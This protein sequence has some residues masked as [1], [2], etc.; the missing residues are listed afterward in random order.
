MKHLRCRS[1]VLA[2]AL[3]VGLPAAAAGQLLPA[4]KPLAEVIDHYLDL[5]LKQE[6]VIPAG[7]ADDATLIRRLTLDLV[8]RIPTPVETKAFVESTDPDKRVRLV[9]RLMAAPAF[10]RHQATELDTMLMYG[11]RMSIR[12]YL[13]QAL[14]E[15]RSWDRI[16]RD[17]VVPEEGDPK[18]K[19]AGEFLK[20]R[21]S[22][23]DRLTNDVSVNFFG[24]NISC[25]QCHDHP[26][27]PDWKQD[28]FFGMKA[29]FGRTFD[30]GGFLAEREFAVIK[31]RTTEGQDRQ[32]RL[33]FLTG[34]EVVETSVKEPSA[35]EQKKERERFETAKKNKTAPPRPTFSARTQLV[36]MALEPGQREFFARSIVN[37]LWHRFYGQGLVMPLDQM[38]S[39]NPPSHPELLEWLAR[40]TAEHNY[41]LRRLI[42][43][44]VLSNAYARDS[45]W[46]KEDAP[47][48]KLFAVAAVR[49]L[50]PMQLA[51]SLSVA[52]SAPTAWPAPES[53]D[54]EKRLANT[55][56]AA[57]GFAGSIEQPRENFQIGVGEALLFSNSDR[58]QKQYL[59]DA[60]NTLIGALK[61][62][63]EEKDVVDVAVRTVFGRPPSEEEGKA[64][65]AFLAK[66]GDRPLQARRDIVWILLTSTEFRFNH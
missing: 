53:D 12:D 46:D 64:L 25:A 56:G 22:D 19:S 30:N 16:F 9:D 31:F 43:G 45:R 32:A 6:N 27:V 5:K 36:Q 55:E 35:E 2:A 47:D 29:F 14:S 57:R 17:V 4:E 59:V 38:H 34:K 11:T 54:F 13:L 63:N 33:M 52:T 62:L 50:T 37:R 41:D 15:G 39:K 23:L 66:R 51:L 60:G 28:H 10:I 3:F 42:R 1:V 26:K 24:V 40:D 20:A 65:G 44:L 58:V 61:A 48:A 8:G 49:P 18:Q 7:P 21:V